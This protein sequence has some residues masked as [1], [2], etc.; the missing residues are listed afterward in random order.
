MAQ[1]NGVP[2]V[3]SKVSSHRIPVIHSTQGR[4][5]II[6]PRK[7]GLSGD[8]RPTLKGQAAVRNPL[9]RQQL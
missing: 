7:S 3:F 6:A 2:P 4:A 5:P 8:N 1:P 9:A